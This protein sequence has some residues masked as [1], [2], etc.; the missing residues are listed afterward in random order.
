MIGGEE[1][2]SIQ[3]TFKAYTNYNSSIETTLIKHSKN[4]PQLE[5]PDQLL[6][7]VELFLNSI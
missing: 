2:K 4:I 3:D 1:N 5:M 7:Q 6:N